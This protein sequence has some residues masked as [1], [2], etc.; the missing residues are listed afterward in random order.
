MNGRM[1]TAGGHGAAPRAD[2]AIV[3]GPT[4]AL[5]S[6]VL[7][8]QFSRR[9]RAEYWYV[10]V[11]VPLAV[12]GFAFTAF[13]M[14]PPLRGAVSAPGVRKLGAASRGLARELLGEDVPPPTAR[15]HVAIGQSHRR[16]GWPTDAARDG[17]AGRA[18][19]YL[20]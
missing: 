17:T 4:A 3:T 2:A 12:A 10:L 6:R 5:L 1:A 11:S 16:D 13:T 15:N 19:G 7:L 20:V 18:R 9:A 8:A 14:I